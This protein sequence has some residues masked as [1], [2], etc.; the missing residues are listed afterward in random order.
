MLFYNF[1]ILG[2][3]N[4]SNFVEIPK[5]EVTPTLGMKLQIEKV[6]Q[7]YSY[8][9]EYA[10]SKSLLNFYG[11]KVTEDQ[12][13]KKTKQFNTPLINNTWGDPDKEFVGK[14]NGDGPDES[15]GIHWKP[16]QEMLQTW[17]NFEF[18]LN[19]KVEDLVG[20]INSHSPI[21]VWLVARDEKKLNWKTI[22]NKSVNTFEN[23]H[24]VLV[25]GYEGDEFNLLGFYIMDPF[26]ENDFIDIDTFKKKWSYFNNVM[27]YRSD[28]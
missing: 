8:S 10:S 3:L 9:C 1:I 14:L 11:V 27:L 19:S 26:F 4:R 6:K 12:L 13:I 7:K 17:G 24:V 18:K 23:E 22:E 28:I 2:I 21:M 25:T 16:I 20:K 15:Y 5:Y